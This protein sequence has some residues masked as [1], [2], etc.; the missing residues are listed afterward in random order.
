MY[1][2]KYGTLI[3]PVWSNYFSVDSGNDRMHVDHSKF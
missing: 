2:K 3:L 1:W